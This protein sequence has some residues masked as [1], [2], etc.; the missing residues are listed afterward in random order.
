LTW[1]TRRDQLYI[2]RQRV[3]VLNIPADF[4]VREPSAQDGHGSLVDFAKPNRLVTG[5]AHT[6][7]EATHARE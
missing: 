5:L 2:L 4:S 6:E 7:L 3:V 1:K